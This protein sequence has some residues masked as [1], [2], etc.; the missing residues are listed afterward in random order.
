MKLFKK[1][2]ENANYWMPLMFLFFCGG[3]LYFEDET[4]P[5]PILLKIFIYFTAI[6]FPVVLSPLFYDFFRERKDLNYIKE[7]ILYVVW[8]ICM[9]TIIW[10]GIFVFVLGR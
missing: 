8:I 6:F 5:Y 4:R 2:E 7:I 1:W 10:N 3:M 9:I